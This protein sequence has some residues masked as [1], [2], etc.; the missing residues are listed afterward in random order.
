MNSYNP[1]I[2][3]ARLARDVARINFAKG[4]TPTN[5]PTKVKKP[6][7]AKQIEDQEKKA[8]KD[9]QKNKYIPNSKAAPPVDANDE[10]GKPIRVE[11]SILG[12]TNSKSAVKGR[13]PE[14]KD[15]LD[16][17]VPYTPSHK[18]LMLDKENHRGII[19]KIIGNFPNDLLNR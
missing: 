10:Q 3:F 13:T 11:P 18:P 17:N 15:A 2:R 14:E 19:H 1:F 7:T 8:E 6:P 4:S 12:T 9:R 5:T 16:I